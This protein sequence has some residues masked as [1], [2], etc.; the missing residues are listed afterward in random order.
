MIASLRHRLVLAIYLSSR[1]FSF[2]LFEG[3]FSPYDWGVHAAGG[4]RKNAC[5]LR[6]IEK[7]LT[8]YEPSA[9]VMQDTTGGG[10]RRADRVQR[11][12]LSIS[13]AA[14]NRGIPTFAYSRLQVRD[15]FGTLPIV[16][17]QTIAEAIAKSIPAFERFLPPPRRPW[18]SE[19][20]RM[21]L[22]D[23][24]ALALTYFHTLDGGDQRAA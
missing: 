9:F 16:T 19:H 18:M 24:A 12:N 15:C 23:A 4:P 22:F 2:V 1:G 21:A 14:D 3:P 7:I 17:K 6:R 10:T 11:L 8:T 20:A 13:E 5:C